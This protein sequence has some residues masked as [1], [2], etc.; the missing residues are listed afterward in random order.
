[1]RSGALA[2]CIQVAEAKRQSAIQS[3]FLCLGLPRASFNRRL[4]PDYCWL[5]NSQDVIVIGG[6]VI[7]L[8][9]AYALAR[10]G[11]MATVLD[12][13]ELG[14][15]AS[16]AGAGMIAPTAERKTD[17]PSV[18]LRSLSAR[19]YPEWSTALRDE[20][21][22]DNGYRRTG[23]VDVAWT[24]DEEHALKV[25][26]GKWREEGIAFER[27]SP[28]D[29]G[30]VEP[31]LNPALRVAYYLP[32]R[33]QIRNPRHLT[34][35]A[36]A[37]LKRGVNLQPGRAALGFEALGERLIAVKTS[38][39]PLACDWVVVAA[40][41][42][43]EQLLEDL[44]LCVPTPPVKGQIV[45]LRFDRPRLTRIVEHGKN[46]LVP[47]DDGRVLVGATEEEVGFD[48]R[49]TPA[50]VRD[51]LDEALRL[52]P[53]LAE[54]EVEKSW[55]GLRPGSIDTRPYLGYA[56]GY[57]NLIV[58]TGHKRAGLQLAPASAEVIV[59]LVL[60]RPPS[61]DLTPFRIG[62][63]PEKIGEDAFRS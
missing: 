55:A 57:R 18:E 17:N 3:L 62:R 13:S 59:D 56:R 42:W 27:L 8:S 58:A 51:L 6:G 19:L 37:V 30:R 23:G 7:G 20:T 32:D 43:S 47:R 41:P 54:A 25:A 29:F 2:R 14:R 45:L 10:E 34:A 12:R 33:A 39:G 1:M 35:L 50:A 52:C 60:G 40:G 21:G 9:I 36:A 53:V 31:A 26:A 61:V 5:M 28:T 16:W 44:G 63:E 24:R 4:S 15:E 22:I 11:V 38:E 49:S 48:K 46:Y